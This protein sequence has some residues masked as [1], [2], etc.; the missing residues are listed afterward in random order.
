MGRELTASRPSVLVNRAA[1][2]VPI[3]V[4]FPE[5][6]GGARGVQ[7]FVPVRVGREAVAGVVGSRLM[8]AAID[9]GRAVLFLG[10]WPGRGR[11]VIIP[12][13]EFIALT[14][15]LLEFRFKVLAVTAVVVGEPLAG[16]LTSVTL[17]IFIRFRTKGIVR[18]RRGRA[19]TVV[20]A[21]DHFIT[22]SEG[23]PVKMTAWITAQAPGRVRS[24]G[25]KAKV[26]ALTRQ[27]DVADI[28]MVAPSRAGRLRLRHAAPKTREPKTKEGSQ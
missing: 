12:P 9:G 28:R 8:A 19:V 14:E 4:A 15:T 11:A 27:I 18:L 23:N 6:F 20:V 21:H 17:A 3:G 25:I 10:L 22:Q 26:V 5:D 2:V 1:V 24:A 7:V 16:V 13:A